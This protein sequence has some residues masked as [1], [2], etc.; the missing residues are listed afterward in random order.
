MTAFIG[1]ID[2]MIVGR[3]KDKFVRMVE[4]G[5]EFLDKVGDPIFPVVEIFRP[6]AKQ[7]KML[8]EPREMTDYLIIEVSCEVTGEGPF[9][10]EFIQ[11]TGTTTSGNEQRPKDLHE[12]SAIIAEVM[13]CLTEEFGKLCLGE[14]ASIRRDIV[15]FAE[16]IETSHC[17]F[18]QLTPTWVT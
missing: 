5:V 17:G 8:R 1:R 7:L 16:I 3:C 2:A 14:H 12:S 13:L 9:C 11:P 4:I 18:S 15:N 10:K 6:I